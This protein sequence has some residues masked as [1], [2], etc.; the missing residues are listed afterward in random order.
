M[1][2]VA[3]QFPPDQ[4]GRQFPLPEIINLP[5]RVTRLERQFA[6]LERE[7]DRLSRQLNVVER[8]V[9]QLNQEVNRLERQV[10]LIRRQCCPR[11]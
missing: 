9:D 7:V 10:D 3:V 2:P 5:A 11:F 1:R 6:A 8:T 4:F